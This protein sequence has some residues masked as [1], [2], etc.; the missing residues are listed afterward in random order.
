MAT[1]SIRSLLDSATECR[2]A[3]SL[4]AAGLEGETASL[5]AILSIGD[6]LLAI[7]LVQA[8]RLEKSSRMDGLLHDN[9][10]WMLERAKRALKPPREIPWPALDDLVGA[11]REAV[12]NGDELP[13]PVAEA[14]RA[15]EDETAVPGAAEADGADGVHVTTGTSDPARGVPL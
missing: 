11:L 7:A 5:Q 9:L 15:L 6:S 2:N 10:P 3:A 12:R 8:A 1:D 13:A 4:A 14:M